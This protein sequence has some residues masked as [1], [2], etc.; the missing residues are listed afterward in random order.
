MKKILSG[1]ILCVLIMAMAVPAFAAEPRVKM[2]LGH[3]LD[4]NSTRHK[5]AVKFA[6]LAAAHCSES[7][8]RMAQSFRL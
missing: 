6:E 3:V 7:V 8:T 1:V 4:Q 5:A 2:R